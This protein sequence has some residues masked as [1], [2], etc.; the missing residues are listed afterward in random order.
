MKELDLSV[1]DIKE[2]ME[3]MSRNKLGKLKIKQNDFCLE[4]EGQK[5]EQMI[6]PAEHVAASAMIATPAV[7]ASAMVAPAVE[8]QQA[9]YNGKLVSAPIV[10]TFYAAPAPDKDPYVT[11]G[12]KVKKGDVL[13]IIESMKLM[14]EVTSDFDGTVTEILVENAQGVEYG[15]PLMVIA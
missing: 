12:S 3:T 2:L 11:I 10:G 6:L 1:Q 7:P 5:I 4:L 15:Q 9:T 8:G 13:F 14:N